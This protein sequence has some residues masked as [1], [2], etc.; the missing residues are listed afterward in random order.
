MK[1]KA[2]GVRP[3]PTKELR[4]EIRALRARVVY[5]RSGLK[6]IETFARVEAARYESSRFSSLGRIATLAANALSATEGGS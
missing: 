4:K 6:Q 1:P 3:P 5:A 2:V